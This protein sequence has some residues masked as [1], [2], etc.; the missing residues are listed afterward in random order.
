MS[1]NPNS[2]SKDGIEAR[3]AKLEEAIGVLSS[4]IEQLLPKAAADP[5]SWTPRMG[6]TVQFYEEQARRKAFVPAIVLERG[7][8]ALIGQYWI[9]QVLSPVHGGGIYVSHAL[10]DQADPPKVGTIRPLAAIEAE[11]EAAA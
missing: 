11:K 7:K 3:V 1:N 9:V 2:P 4:A 6:E 8:E 10:I 5:E